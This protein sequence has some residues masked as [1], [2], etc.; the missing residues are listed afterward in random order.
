MRRTA[1]ILTAL[2]M[3]ACRAKTPGSGGEQPVGATSEPRAISEARALIGQGQLDA[4]LAK[5][6]AAPETPECLYYRGVVWM[7]KADSVPLPTPP[8]ADPAA[9]AGSATRAPEFKDEE[10]RAID[11]FERSIAAQPQQSLAHNALADLLAPHAIRRHEIER[12]ASKKPSP[13]SGAQAAPSPEIGAGPDFSVRR[14]ADLY[15]KACQGDPA[16]KTIVDGLLRFARRVESD[17]DLDWGLRELARRDSENPEA[18]V[19]MGDF[20]I[21]RRQ[22]GR[23]AIEQYRQA[24]IWRPDDAAIKAKIG[25]IYVAM[26]KEHFEA[27]E[28]AIAEARLTEA[29]KYITD[30]GS[31]QA[32]TMNDYL[33]RLR[34]IRR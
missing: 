33:E 31:P 19:R 25:A 2:V 5:L 27:H 11:F 1:L 21:E 8:P 22:D 23:G 18:F 4:A 28:Y 14:V 20:L 26:G 16:S 13:R 32:A 12:A 9:P 29:Q 7:R 15:R 17:D 24:L 34:A 10:L 6:L 3:V 30:K